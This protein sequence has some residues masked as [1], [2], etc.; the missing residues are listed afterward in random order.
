[1]YAGVDPGSRYL[2]PAIAEGD[3]LPLKLR[4]LKTL[5]VGVDVPLAK[6]KRIE[7]ADRVIEIKTK[8]TITYES[9]SELSDQVVETLLKHRV[10][11]LVIEFAIE[12]HINKDAHAQE[13]A[14]I[15][16]ELLKSLWLGTTIAERARAKG[17]T[18]ILTRAATWRPK[19]AVRKG[20]GDAD[21]EVA[22]AL[23]GHFSNWPSEPRAT[24]THKR[25][26]SGLCA[27]GAML[28]DHPEP[29]KRAPAI[30]TSP[31]GGKQLHQRKLPVGIDSP[32]RKAMLEGRVNPMARSP[33]PS[34]VRRSKERAAKRREAGCVCES[35]RHRLSCPLAKVVKIIPPS[36][37][38]S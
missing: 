25:D 34:E 5:G 27:F 1:V 19:V 16:T 4:E 20:Q 37:I 38:A 12:V 3:K 18:V 35:K 2:G 8:R 7:F 21:P 15:G 22:A 11:F 14:G 36:P 23:A 31:R 26:A 32:L 10:K 9:M 29:R 30:V 33:S 6:P 17:I 28:Q 13:A 24:D